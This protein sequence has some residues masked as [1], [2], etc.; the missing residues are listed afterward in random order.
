[1]TYTQ[2][3][4]KKSDVP[5]KNLTI[6]N[7]FIRSFQPCQRDFPQDRMNGYQPQKRTKPRK[8][9]IRKALEG[10]FCANRANLSI[11]N[12]RRC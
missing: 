7:E 4:L 8:K 10:R 6:T 12:H 11:L 2:F 3:N 1:M 5:K 9:Q